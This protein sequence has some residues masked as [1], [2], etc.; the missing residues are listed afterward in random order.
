MTTAVVSFDLSLITPFSIIVSLVG[1]IIVF[2]ALILL[3]QVY[4]HIPKLLH[5]EIRKKLRRAGK[6]KQA[7]KE[8]SIPGEV[9][10]AIS[11][12][13]FLHFNAQHDDESGVVTIKRVSK[14]YSPWSSKI[15]GLNTYKR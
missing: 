8:L 6:H 4:T 10:A 5:L 9:S 7:E 13:L 15:Y 1:Y 3:A 2:T 14:R 12:A 11:L